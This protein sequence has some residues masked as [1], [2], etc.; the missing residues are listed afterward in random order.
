MADVNI[1][2][3]GSS[4]ATMDADGA[5]TL[6]TK[7]KYCKDDIT[8]QYAK[9]SGI[10]PVE[11]TWN[12]VPAHVQA[13]LNWAAANPYDPSDYSNS[14]FDD[15]EA[16]HD[17]N[18]V[19]GALTLPAGKLTVTDGYN[20]H[21]YSGTVTAGSKTIYNLIP[22]RSSYAVENNGN[23]VAVGSLIPTGA[24]RF[25]CGGGT[26][27]QNMRDLGGIPCNGG[28]IKFGKIIRGGAVYPGD[29]ETVRIL[30][31]EVGIRAELDLLNGHLGYTS[32]PIGD[33]VDFCCPIADSWDWAYY[34]LTYTDQMREAFRFI[35][36][37]V[38]RGRMLYMHCQQ[39]ADRTGTLAV[40]VEGLLGV[41]QSNIDVDYE[42][43]SFSSDTTAVRKRSN[44]AYKALMTNI[45]AM[46]GSTFQMKV[47]NYVASLG[48]TAAEINAFITAMV[49]GNPAT[50]TPSISIYT[51]TNTLTHATNDND[52]QN[53]TQYQPYEANIKAANGYVI[54]SVTVTM[55]GADVTGQVF[56]G[57]Q[58]V[59]RREVTNTLTHCTTNNTKI[60]VIQGEGYGATIT[61]DS[62]Y[63]LDGATIQIT[64]GGIDVSNYYS[65]G[66]IAIP[67]VTGNIAITITAVESAPAYHNLADP[68]SADW[69]TGYRISNSGIVAQARKTVSNPVPVVIGDVIRVKGVNFVAGEDRYQLN[70]KNGVGN[71]NTYRAY[72]SVLPDM[73]LN[74]TLDGDVHVF[75]V[76]YQ[77]LVSD[78]SLCFAFSTPSDPSVVIITK[79][80]EIS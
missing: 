1:T 28:A 33:D 18:P 5:K 45:N 10:E 21:S 64:M 23:V 32:S 24:R 30:H 67:S 53:A 16:V 61:P 15:H 4:I 37:S 80:E 2:Y 65:G 70:S 60:S 17:D 47:V 52:A 26:Y 9:P 49:D 63:T 41:S 6:N 55:G 34:Y 71:D 56:S 42:L 3:K 13:F 77:N 36:D 69:K 20:G 66:K 39:G 19:G 76:V 75:T 78:G 57:E 73:A 72:V 31:D 35:F 79:N 22:G 48:F 14:Y 29:P 58:T 62:G 74:Y 12:I 46:N 68:T 51:V 40:L 11:K 7:G 38:A 50:V 59:L 8:V 25:I 44:S 43:T 27:D 54:D